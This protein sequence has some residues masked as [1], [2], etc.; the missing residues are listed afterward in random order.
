MADGKIF[1][2]YRREDSGGHAGRI[3]DRLNARFPG[4]VAVLSCPT[5][6][7]VF[8]SPPPSSSS[9]VSRR[10]QPERRL[11]RLRSTRS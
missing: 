2:C 8:F 10:L 4:R 6:S 7:G 5:G 11:R 1:I 3:Y 9:L